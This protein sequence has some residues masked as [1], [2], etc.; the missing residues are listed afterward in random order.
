MS[1]R[2][3]LGCMLISLD[4]VV[5]S[6]SGL[7]DGGGRE[8]DGGE[9]VRRNDLRLVNGERLVSGT[10]GETS[11]EEKV[12]RL[13]GK[14]K[15]GRE[16]LK[17]AQGRWRLPPVPQRECVSSPSARSAQHTLRHE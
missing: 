17:Q 1:L 14:P 16:M 12:Q 11:D 13:R 10:L 5:G 4:A 8:R 15:E 2:Q 3:L 7:E 9:K 6:R